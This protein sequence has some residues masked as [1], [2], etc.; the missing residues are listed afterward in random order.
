MVTQETKDQFTCDCL[1]SKNRLAKD[2]NARRQIIEILKAPVKLTA[3]DGESVFY[4]RCVF[5]NSDDLFFISL[6]DSPNR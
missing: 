5:K 2:F 1:K 4:P 6:F 3:E